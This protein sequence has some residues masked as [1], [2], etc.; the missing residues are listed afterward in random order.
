MNLKTKLNKFPKLNKQIPS[1][2]HKT[3]TFSELTNKD[4]ACMSDIDTFTY[5]IPSDSNQAENFHEESSSPF[6]PNSQVNFKKINNWLKEED[7]K[8]C[9]LVEK[10]KKRSWKKIASEIG[11]KSDS[12]CLH[13]WQKVLDPSLVK[14]LWTKEEDDKIIQLVNIY[15]PQKWTV[16]SRSL[17]GRIGKQIRERWNNHLSPR[18]TKEKWFEEEEYVLWIMHSLI[19]NKWS[20]ISKFIPGRTDN[21]IKNHWNSIMKKKISHIEAE[22]K[23]MKNKLIKENKKKS[24]ISIKKEILL[25]KFDVLKSEYSKKWCVAEEDFLKKGMFPMKELN[26]MINKTIK[27]GESIRINEGNEESQSQTQSQVLLSKKRINDVESS[28]IK[29]SCQSSNNH[30]FIRHIN[31]SSSDKQVF[32]PFNLHTPNGKQDNYSKYNKDNKENMGNMGSML[33]PSSCKCIYKYNNSN[34]SI[35]KD[36]SLYYNN[37]QDEFDFKNKSCICNN[38]YNSNRSTVTTPILKKSMRIASRENSSER[39]FS[40]TNNHNQYASTDAYTITP[41]QSTQSIQFTTQNQKQGNNKYISNTTYTSNIVNTNN[42]LQLISAFTTDCTKQ[43]IKEVSCIKCYN[44]I[45]LDFETQI[46]LLQ[47]YPN[48][49][50]IQ[51]DF[52]CENCKNGSML[53]HD[54]PSNNYLPSF[55]LSASKVRVPGDF[56]FMTTPKKMS[57]LIGTPLFT[58][59]IGCRF[60]FSNT[61]RE[62]GRLD[63]RDERDDDCNDNVYGSYDKDS[64]GMLSLINREGSYCKENKDNNEEEAEKSNKKNINISKIY[65]NEENEGKGSVVQKLLFNFGGCNGKV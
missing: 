25:S 12:Q 30:K 53:F 40:N 1:Q 33:N 44:K 23:E 62:D 42:K 43:N 55:N 15:G 39:K 29:Q 32:I 2:S 54:L 57:S 59:G 4:N 63:I 64:R 56:L 19:G 61:K 6:P 51:I 21:N 3:I 38:V 46:N 9:F 52:Q 58:K 7:E 5:Q 28:Q 10:Y 27:I 48:T 18:V 31:F 37:I 41:I 36:K 47:E 17:P 26:K 34:N 16:I 20:F 11:T 14:G 8:L 49:F 24:E 50:A 13:R 35:Y 22:Y 45:N 65:K 60:D